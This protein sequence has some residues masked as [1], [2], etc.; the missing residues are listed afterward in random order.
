[1]PHSI[2]LCLPL[3]A[4][5]MRLSGLLGNAKR[6][7]WLCGSSEML[8]TILRELLW[9]KQGHGVRMPILQSHPSEGEIHKSI[10]IQRQELAQLD[11]RDWFSRM[12]VL[13]AWRSL[14]L[15]LNQARVELGSL[16]L[17]WNRGNTQADKHMPPRPEH[18][19]LHVREQSPLFSHAVFLKEGSLEGTLQ[20]THTGSV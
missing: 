9:R 5:T 13:D 7:L 1:M 17:C 2:F 18:M 8:M 14:T 6:D 3:Y 10:L 15:A 12:P 4:H 19:L 20:P 11:Q 16:S